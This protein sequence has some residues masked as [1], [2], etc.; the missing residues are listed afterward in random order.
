MGRGADVIDLSA[1][2][3]REATIAAGIW[4]TFGVGAFGE[5]Y[6]A[7]TWTRPHRPGLA[8]LFALA[9]V[10]ALAV[11]A[12]PREQ[13]VRSRMREPFFLAWTMLDFAM[14]V[15]GTLLD[16]GTASPLVLVFFIPVVF[17]SMSYPLGSVVTVGAVSV[18]SYLALALTVGG[19]SAEYEGGFIIALVCTAAMSAWQAQ[20]HNRQHRALSTASR[21]DS[22]TGCLNRRGFEERAAAELRAMARSGARGAILVF[23]ID[24]FK[25]VNDTFGHAAGDRLLCW[26]A[27]TLE[28]SVRPND[29]VG[30]LGGD[31][32]AAVFPELDA[33]PA[34]AS[35]ER[36]VAVLGERAPASFGIAIFP[37]DG[38]NLE[39]L[40][41]HADGA[42]YAS[43]QA[44]RHAAAEKCL[45]DSGEPSRLGEDM[46]VPA[47]T[48]HLEPTDLWRAALDAMPNRQ[49]SS[50]GVARDLHSE[51]LDQI[52]ASVICTDM[53]G[54]V[55]CWN[56][57]A[58]ALYGWSAEEA[59]GR[60][61]RELMVPEDASAA[62]RL[63]AELS[64][65]GRWDGEL[66]VRRKD[67]SLFTAYLRNR[68]VLDEQGEPAAIVGVAVDIS[69]RVAAE[70]ER[71]RDAE[72]LACLHR[73]ER[74]LA[75]DR[76]VLHA[77]PIIDVASGKTVQ[78]ELLLRMR[79]ADG[80]LIYP[81]DFLPVAERY[82]LIGQIDRWVVERATRLAGTGDPVHLNL[83]AR[84]VG[85]PDVL[86]HIERC[87]ERN[88]VAPGLL[89]F[90][91]TETAIV[92]DARA[93]GSFAERLH[94]LGCRVALDDFGTGYGTLTYLKEIP[95]DY[96]KLDIE[97]VRDL[98]SNEASRRVVQAVISLARDFGLQTVAEGVE[99][100]E[101]LRLLAH[102]GVD[103][104]QG[105]YIARPE[106]FDV[107][108]CDR[109][110]S[111]RARK[112]AAK[113]AARPARQPTSAA[114]RD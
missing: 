62:E 113:H 81:G 2:R 4:L 45:A 69:A 10:A 20:N 67:G 104:A 58:E 114:P 49:R 74:A 77:Q 52:D 86:A 50:G 38:A 43:R 60:S 24:H 14:L 90:E 87:I 48:Q 41:R 39:D 56:K 97:F 44:R 107:R 95:V 83:S 17:S 46:L 53:A 57:G 55:L 99:D 89:V 31:E 37:D 19:A 35:A 26:F 15:V 59:V 66:L 91:F 96:L 80:T 63:R 79:E 94:E 111:A 102:F 51:L 1:M 98:R 8:V 105:Y 32:F 23:D 18:I 71:Q 93:A 25:P 78:H 72:T 42:L 82:A 33:G 84:S 101:T 103:R 76:F 109:R 36:I 85:D 29:A 54:V 3:M 34:R 11:L 88:R 9:V 16:G 21:T 64:T 5:A 110:R 108:P 30:R 73:V 106:A 68:L 27:Q 92:E 75:E 12:L 13:I 7:L 112:R 40:T 70:S 100:A 28:K 22:L 61:A 65:D 47:T 6:V